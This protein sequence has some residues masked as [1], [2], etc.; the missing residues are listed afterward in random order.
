MCCCIPNTGLDE[1]SFCYSLLEK[2]TFKI[3]LNQS[4]PN[5]VF[6][7]AQ[8]DNSVS[9]KQC[10]IWMKNNRFWIK[11]LSSSSFCLILRSNHDS[12]MVRKNETKIL[13]HNDIIYTGTEQNVVSHT[14]LCFFKFG[15]GKT[16]DE[17]GLIESDP[18]QKKNK[19]NENQKKNLFR[20]RSTRDPNKKPIGNSS[21][22]QHRSQR[23]IINLLNQ[24]PLDIDTKSSDDIH[25]NFDDDDNDDDLDIE[26]LNPKKPSI[27]FVDDKL[28]LTPQEEADAFLGKK[29]SLTGNNKK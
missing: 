7:S 3:N 11:N 27:N 20:R 15:I 29:R 22:Q 4:N 10:Q 14:T 8:A 5:K 24:A 23:D 2:E 16:P 25:P 9:R 19:S 13:Y 6:L 12:I 28:S 18:I 17:F 1:H 21:V 26:N